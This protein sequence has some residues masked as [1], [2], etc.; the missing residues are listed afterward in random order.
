MHKSFQMNIEKK[1]RTKNDDHRGQT[2]STER[3]SH[4]FIFCCVHFVFQL[5]L[6]GVRINAIVEFPEQL[7]LLLLFII[8]HIP[9]PVIVC[10][11]ILKLIQYIYLYKL[12]L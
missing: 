10:S 12:F 9:I 5:R 4:D 11:R 2:W 1:N 8:A 7:L 3:N 6:Y